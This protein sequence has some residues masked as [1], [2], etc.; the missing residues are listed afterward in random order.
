MPIDI[1]DALCDHP[2]VRYAVAI[3]TEPGRG[4]FSAAVLL[5]AAATADTNGL[6]AFVAEQRG[7]HLVPDAI[8]AVD[9]MPITEQGKPDRAA[10]TTILGDHRART[11]S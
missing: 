7:R 4:G 8:V 5:A 1:Q 11:H 2:A 6:M 10:L 3:P 9:R